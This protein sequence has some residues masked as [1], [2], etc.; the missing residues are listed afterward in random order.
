M[1]SKQI[2]FITLGVSVITLALVVELGKNHISRTDVIYIIGVLTG[3]G[4]IVGLLKM[5]D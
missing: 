1:N 3:A 4:F 2:G 5:K